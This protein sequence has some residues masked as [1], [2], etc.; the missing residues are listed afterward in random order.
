MFRLRLAFYWSGDCLNFHIGSRHVRTAAVN[1][2]FI[3]MVGSRIEWNRTI[4]WNRIDY[5]MG[6][7]P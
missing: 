2:A 3:H 6:L 7:S 5:I 1:R 4:E